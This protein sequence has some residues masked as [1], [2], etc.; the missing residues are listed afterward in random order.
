MSLVKGTVEVAIPNNKFGK[1]AILINEKWYNTKPEWI[2]TT[3]NKGDIVEF[4]D[5]GKNYIK[6]IKVVGQGQVTGGSQSSPK[7]AYNNLGVELG[8]ASKLAMD[9]TLASPP[10]G[11]VGSD[12]F[13]TAWLTHTEKI[14]R[15]MTEL[16]ER[17]SKPP[18]VKPTIKED[19]LPSDIF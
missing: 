13:Y 10:N 9:V 6:N 11:V 14:H 17:I 19:N 4:D 1:F 8:H 12:D 15:C 5:G 2:N 3:V 18:E 7:P 16:R